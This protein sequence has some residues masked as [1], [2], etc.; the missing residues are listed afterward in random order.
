MSTIKRGNQRLSKQPR[1]ALQRAGVQPAAAQ[2]SEYSSDS[3]GYRLRPPEG[4]ERASKQGADVLFQSPE[5]K[6]TNLGVTVT[7]VRIAS[8]DRFGSLSIVG[9]RLLNVERGKVQRCCAA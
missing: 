3:Q 2:A 8:L 4:W 1:Q 6:G 7:P 5:E 9:E